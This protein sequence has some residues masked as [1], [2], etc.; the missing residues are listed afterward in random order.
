[1]LRMS[2]LADLELIWTFFPPSKRQIKAKL[3]KQ[4]KQGIHETEETEK[5]GEFQNGE[6]REN[7]KTEKMLRTSILAVLGHL[8]AFSARPDVAIGY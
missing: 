1:M 5:T 8:D 3:V 4:G 6:N 7:G 2:I